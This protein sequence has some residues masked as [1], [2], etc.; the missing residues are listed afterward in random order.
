MATI[1]L[2]HQA[3]LRYARELLAANDLTPQELALR[4]QSCDRLLAGIDRMQQWLDSVHNPVLRAHLVLQLDAIRKEIRRATPVQRSDDLTSYSAYMRKNFGTDPLQASKLEEYGITPRLLAKILSGDWEE[5]LNLLTNNL[6]PR[7]E[8]F[9]NAL[10]RS[11]VQFIHGVRSFE[12]GWEE[13]DALM[14]E[15]RDVLV[16][17]YTSMVEESPL[18]PKDYSYTGA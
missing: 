11:I 18:S 5:V 4:R 15:Y 7:R 14:I 10:V 17:L 3:R 1:E 2:R 8:E 6:T 12:T 16:R 13:Y 9:A